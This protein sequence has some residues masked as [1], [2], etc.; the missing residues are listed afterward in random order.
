MKF[1]RP[2]HNLVW[3]DHT[4][5]PITLFCI[6]AQAAASLRPFSTSTQNKITTNEQRHMAKRKG[7][8]IQLLPDS[9]MIAWITIGPITDDATVDKPKSPKNYIKSFEKDTNI[10]IYVNSP[11]FHT[12]AGWVQPSLSGQKHRR[13][14]GR[15]RKWHCTS[16]TKF[17][18]QI[19][20]FKKK[21]IH[22][23][24][25]RHYGSFKRTRSNSNANHYIK[26]AP[27]IGPDPKHAPEWYQDCYYRCWHELTSFSF[28]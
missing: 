24:I 25:P 23:R 27:N 16:Y 8:P 14:L 19:L 15:G 1:I 18:R 17:Q 4:A 9:S 11:C 21:I 5:F 26:D 6:T 12:R 7:N 28:S 10:A 3:A 13:V 22:T 20:N 2:S